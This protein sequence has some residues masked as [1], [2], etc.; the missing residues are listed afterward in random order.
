MKKEKPPAQKNEEVAKQSKQKSTKQT[1]SPQNKDKS[2]ATNLANS[3]KDASPALANNKKDSKSEEQKD[4]IKNDQ[5]KSE[6]DSPPAKKVKT[7]TMS[8][9]FVNKKEVKLQSSG[10]DQ[11]DTDYNPGKSKYHPINDAFWKHNEK[12]I[13]FVCFFFP[14]CIIFYLF[15]KIE[16]H[17]WP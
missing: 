14:I 11:E 3:E 10:A 7:D 12:Y 2:K 16:F 5:V 1:K 8:S 6:D 13:V 15:P 9:F 17:I 4:T